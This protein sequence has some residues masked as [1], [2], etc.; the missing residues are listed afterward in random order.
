MISSLG[1]SSIET[2]MQWTCACNHKRQM[3]RARAKRFGFKFF[4]FG[5]FKRLTCESEDQQPCLIYMDRCLEAVA[6]M[7][8][9]VSKWA[10]VS[11]EFQ[12]AAM[13]LQTCHTSASPDVQIQGRF[14]Q[15][16]CR[17][18]KNW[19][20]L[21]WKSMTVTPISLDWRP[22]ANSD[23]SALELGRQ[24]V[25]SSCRQQVPC[26]HIDTITSTTSKRQLQTRT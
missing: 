21:P 1:K 5:S 11:N 18:Y 15:H 20:E 12:P 13:R 6:H 24:P 8:P 19:R 26:T 4:R 25:H 2:T 16:T 7:Y 14:D 10:F 17:L 22:R 9:C 3:R 23:W